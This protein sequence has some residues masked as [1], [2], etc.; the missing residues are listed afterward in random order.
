LLIAKFA[1]LTV[2]TMV[3]DEARLPEVPVMVTIAIP[4]VAVLLAA[5]ANVLFPVEGLGEKD[6]VTPLGNPDAAKFTL[7]VNPHCGVTLMVAVAVLPSFML[8]LSVDEKRRKPG[9]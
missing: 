3:V 8:R 2:T 9:G 7:P 1:A 4:G 6:A 5:S